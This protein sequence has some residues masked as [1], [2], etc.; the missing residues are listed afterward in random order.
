[1]IND[2]KI[3]TNRKWAEIWKRHFTEEDIRWQV[4]TRK[5]VHHHCHEGENQNLKEIHI[6]TGSFT[7]HWGECKMLPFEKSLWFLIQSHVPLTYHP[8]VPVLDIY[9]QK[10]KRTVTRK[11]VCEYLKR[12][13]LSSPK[14]GSNP[15]I[16]PPR[17][18][19]PSTGVSRGIKE[20]QTAD[21]RRMVSALCGERQQ[22]RSRAP[23]DLI[24][25][26]LWERRYYEDA[27]S[28]V[29]WGRG[30]GTGEF[31]GWWKCFGLLLWWYLHNHVHLSKLITLYSKE[32]I[33]LYAN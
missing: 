19:R 24:F 18:P 10:R 23:H 17:V 32:W 20:E 16:L 12:L 4:D 2:R 15:N 29:A 30:G 14:R 33:L 21:Y 31:G 22:V 3:T 1:M 25:M 7:P 11:P 13:F 8:A 26:E 5:N 9:P 6:T 27:E 28:M